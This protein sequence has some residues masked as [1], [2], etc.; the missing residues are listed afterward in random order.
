MTAQVTPVKS[1]P[2]YK[3]K[4]AK[5]SMNLDQQLI[6]SLC[7]NSLF[8]NLNQLKQQRKYGYTHT[9]AESTQPF[10]LVLHRNKVFSYRNQCPHTSVSL[11]YLPHQ[12]LNSR[13]TFIQCARMKRCLKLIPVSKVSTELISGNIYKRSTM[14]PSTGLYF[15]LVLVKLNT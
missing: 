10:L 9:V 3:L 15:L 7:K 11:N 2:D 12:F 6:K 4:H 13:E 14:A 5:L 8:A 1:G